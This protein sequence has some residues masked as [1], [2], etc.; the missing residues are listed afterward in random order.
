VDS[1]ERFKQVVVAHDWACALNQ[2]SAAFCW[3]A[4]SYDDVRGAAPGSRPGFEICERWPAL[5]WCNTR[6]AAVTGGFRFR[7]LSRM[8]R[9]GLMVGLTADGRAYAWGGDRV[10]KPLHAEQRWTSISGAD[11]GQCGVTTAGELFCWG[12]NP[13]DAVQGRVAHPPVEA[14]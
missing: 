14:G 13:H 8:P 3:G 7:S 1:R 2:A 6:P 10:P 11:W 12:R 4:A 9:D 5:T